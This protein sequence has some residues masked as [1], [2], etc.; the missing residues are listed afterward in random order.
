[1]TQ[2]LAER[3]RRHLAGAEEVSPPLSQTI[4]PG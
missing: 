4:R 1:M 3:L 2:R